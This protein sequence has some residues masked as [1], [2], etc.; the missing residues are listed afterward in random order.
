MEASQRLL[1]GESK[2]PQEYVIDESRKRLKNSF[3]R[4]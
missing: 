1:S 4:S 2:I 3:P